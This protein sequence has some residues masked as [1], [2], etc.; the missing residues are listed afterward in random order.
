MGGV[1]TNPR[2]G[3]RVAVPPVG[4]ASGDDYVEAVLRVVE[5][6]PSGRVLAYG[7]IA[8]LLGVGGPRQV[9]RVLSLHGGGVPWWRVIRADGSPPACNEIRARREWAAEATPL[10][11][12]GRVH[13]AR[14][15]W[16]G[17]P[18]GCESWTCRPG[19]CAGHP[20]R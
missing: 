15:R 10:R 19:V 1:P 7:D 2:P 5:S 16:T 8:E 12:D 9:G 4:S 13:M 3:G 20:L 18:G 11:P 14:A 17:P 6:I